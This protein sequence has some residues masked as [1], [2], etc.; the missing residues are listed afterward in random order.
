MPSFAFLSAFARPADR[1]VGFINANRRMLAMGAVCASGLLT[2]LYA[3]PASAEVVH[4][5]VVVSQLQTYVAPPIAIETV[6]RDDFTI[7]DYTLV[8][9]PVPPTTEMSSGFGFRSC[10]GCSADH[11]GIDL[12]PGNGYPIQAIADGVVVL[13]ADDAGGLGVHVVIEHTVNGQVVRSLYAHMQYGSTTL[14]VGQAVSRGQQVG[15][16]GN[17][18]ASTGPHLHFGILIG[19]V[20]VDP[21]AW[22]VANVAD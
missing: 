16:V 21:Q 3:M 6:S 18:G 11:L 8:Q 19:G 9:W 17:T 2:G 5:E 14:A 13:A 12:N 4:E 10:T 1:H 20:E 7:T 15:L 22:L